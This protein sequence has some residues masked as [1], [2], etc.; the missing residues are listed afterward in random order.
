MELFLLNLVAFLRPLA[1][2]QFAAVVFEIAGVGLFGLIVL[3]FLSNSALRK[4][5]TLSAVD[6]AIIAFTLWCLSVYVIYF[7]KARISEVVKMLIPMLSY[8]VVKNVVTSRA[9]YG[10]LLLWMIAGFSLPLLASI[11]L[12][13]T[14][15]GLDYVSYWTG[16]PRWEGAYTGAHNMGHSMTLLIIALVVYARIRRNDQQDSPPKGRG[17]VSVVF[18]A[19][20]AMAVYC[21]YMSQVRSAILGLIV[22]SGVYL[23]FYNR[24]LLLFGSIAMA[25]LAAVTLPIWMPV[26]LPDVW[27]VQQGKADVSAIGSGRQSFWLHNLGVYAAL[28]IDRQLAGVGIGNRDSFSEE[29][30]LDSHNDWLDVLMQTGAIGVVLLAAIQ[31][32][33]LRSILRM[34]SEERFAYLAVFLAVNVMMLV[35]NSFVWRIQVSH[36]YFMLLAY[37]EIRSLS[38]A[39]KAQSTFERRPGGGVVLESDV[40]RLG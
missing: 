21:L 18:L 3:V 16:I 5:I 6:L 19:I 26:L 7:D 30:V 2:M 36:L 14:G 9:D 38:P 17:L 27:L 22:F 37:I 1:S 40:R 4:A 33:L 24:K 31:L 10:K 34:A 12:I 39:Q 8:I 28:P 29:D 20:A 11:Y 13:T 35:S 25:V 23:F 15:Q 32:L